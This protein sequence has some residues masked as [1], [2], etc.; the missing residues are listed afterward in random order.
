MGHETFSRTGTEPINQ[1]QATERKRG[2]HAHVEREREREREREQWVERSSLPLVQ[3]FR[4]ASSLLLSHQLV[5]LLHLHLLSLCA[6]MITTTKIS[7]VSVAGSL[8]LTVPT[9]AGSD[10]QF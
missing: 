8:F 6:A 9:E 3:A 5:C 10:R 1:W 4:G 7:G 2:T